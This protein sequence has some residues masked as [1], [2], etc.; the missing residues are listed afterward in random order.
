MKQMIS[1]RRIMVLL[2]MSAIALLGKAQSNLVSYPAKDQFNSSDFNPAFLTNQHQYTFSIFPLAGMS[3]GYNDQYVVNKMLKN[4]LVGSKAPLDTNVLFN[5]L[6]KRDLF[7]QRFESTLLNF[8]YNSTFGSFSFR[9]KDVEQLMLNLN[10]NFSNFLVN[11]AYNTLIINQPQLFPVNMVHYREYSI[12]FAKEIIR[13][14]LYVGVRTKL[15]FGKASLSSE[16]QGE[17][18]K[19]NNIFYLRTS[20]SMKLSAPVNIVLDDSGILQPFVLDNNFSP[21]NYIFNSKNVGTGI[22]FGIIYKFNPRME[23][24]VSI[25]DLGKINWKDNSNEIFFNGEYEFPQEYTVGSNA[26]SLTKS[27]NFAN[28]AVN[29]YSLFKV[30]YNKTVYST[31]LPTNFYFGLQYLL[32]PKLNIGLVDR[33][34]SMKGLTQSS[35]SVTSNYELSKKITLC[36]GYSVIGNSYFNVPFAILYK[37]DS[38][39]SFFG[40]NNLL[41]F[42]PLTTAEFSGITFGTCFYLFNRRKKYND[43]IQ[44]L[45]FYMEKKDQSVTKK[46]LIYNN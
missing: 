18:V 41:S 3:I 30:N 46:G 7:S 15:Y 14:K 21:V 33:Y 28:A 8:G 40:T 27:P 19:E 20:G 36:T 9:I 10:G 35:F 31:P 4:F 34:I 25:V 32:T 1:T 23:L 29:Y 42:L 16:I 12:G 44:Y 45:P 39:Q 38:G 22:D 2:M 5:S 37:W 24:S 11:P 26:N 43:Q 13:N 6:V 17:L